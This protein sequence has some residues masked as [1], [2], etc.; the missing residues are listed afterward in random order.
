MRLGSKQP[1][2]AGVR[3]GAPHRYVAT[4]DPG[5]ATGLASLPLG[6]QGQVAP[7]AMT[8]GVQRHTTCAVP[9]CGR[10]REAPIHDVEA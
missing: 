3:A 1:A 2:T 8:S 4:T 7:A 5:L 10:E 9:G 6:S